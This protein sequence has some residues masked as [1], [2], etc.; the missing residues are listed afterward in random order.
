MLLILFNEHTLDSVADNFGKLDFVASNCE[1]LACEKLAAEDL[2]QTFAFFILVILL[3]LFILYL[4]LED[5]RKGVVL[6]FFLGIP[7]MLMLFWFPPVDIC[8]EGK[9]ESCLKEI[10]FEKRFGVSNPKE[11][12][13]FEFTESDIILAEHNK[14][15]E[16]IKLR[17]EREDDWFHQKFLLVGMLLFGFAAKLIVDYSSSM[18]TESKKGEQTK[19][20]PPESK[21]STVNHPV[22]AVVAI[23]LVVAVATCIALAIDAH[24]RSIIS[25]AAQLGVWIHRHIED[26]FLLEYTFL[27]WETFIRHGHAVPDTGGMHTDVIWRFTWPHLHIITWLLYSTYLFLLFQ[28]W[29]QI[30]IDKDPGDV[31]NRLKLQREWL[32][33]SFWFV[34]LLLFG[35]AW[36]AH[37]YPSAFFTKPWPWSSVYEQSQLHQPFLYVLLSAIL[38]MTVWCYLKILDRKYR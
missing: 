9:A 26:R 2:V 20:E 19:K 4:P 31:H 5:F 16:E 27:G 28:A 22:S 14:A 7:V 11:L 8:K 15:V 36:M 34:H 30:K 17:I 13:I 25:G 6:V 35:F 32:I 29:K 18:S 38:M 3:A 23:C 12:S 1:K 21:G 33:I 37:G 24:L 10:E